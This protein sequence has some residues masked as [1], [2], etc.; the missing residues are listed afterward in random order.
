[1]LGRMESLE[2][3]ALRTHQ[4]AQG[5]AGGVANI[6]RFGVLPLGVLL[7]LLLVL[8]TSGRIVRRILRIEENARRLESGDALREADPSRDEIGTLSRLLVAMGERLRHAQ[9]ELRH[10]GDDR[11]ADRRVEPA[12]VPPDRGAPAGARPERRQSV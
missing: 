8:A 5:R 3:E 9:D 12:R 7:S 6:L 10:L 4:A 2:E 11:S 1:M